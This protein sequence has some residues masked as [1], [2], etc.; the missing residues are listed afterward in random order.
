MHV[1]YN[2]YMFY[3]RVIKLLSIQIQLFYGSSL[4]IVR[5]WSD[6]TEVVVY[7]SGGPL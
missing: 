4:G 1:F 3:T 6:E 2:G 7:S 5:H